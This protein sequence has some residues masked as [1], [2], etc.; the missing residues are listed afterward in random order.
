MEK[1]MNKRF[2][3]MLIA[4]MIVIVMA[5]AAIASFVTAKPV[6]AE[7]DYGI[8]PYFCN[9][10]TETVVIGG[11]QFKYKFDGNDAVW[12]L[13][14][15]IKVTITSVNGCTFKYD[16]KI[17]FF[18]HLGGD[19]AENPNDSD[20]SIWSGTATGNVQFKKDGQDRKYYNKET[21]KDEKYNKYDVKRARIDITL[22]YNG[23]T[24]TRAYD[25][26]YHL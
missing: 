11:E 3:F 16:V 14:D 1:S 23:V 13:W 12:P 17:T 19:D 9:D 8:E 20:K 22:T 7:E 26:L 15:S 18:Y 2:A 4:S 10:R 24:D 5:V 6:L 21:G 25:L